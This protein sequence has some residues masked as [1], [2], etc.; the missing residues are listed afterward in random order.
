MEQSGFTIQNKFSISLNSLGFFL[1]SYLFVY[2][3]HQIVTCV[4]ATFFHIP[5]LFRYNN[6]LFYADSSSWTFTSVKTIFLSGPIV[7]LFVGIFFLII[8]HRFHTYDGLLRLFF[9]WGAI[10]A[11]NLFYGAMIVGTFTGNGIG[12]A[13]NWMFLMDTGKLLVVILALTCSLVT[14]V[15]LTRMILFTANSYFPA[16]PI[17]QKRGYLRAQLLY[18]FLSGSL[19]LY[20][21]KS[22]VN[23]NDL[24]L[25]ATLMLFIIPMFL[26]QTH[27]PT[28]N[29]DNE[30]SHTI[31]INPILM[32]CT[33]A[34]VILYRTTLAHGIYFGL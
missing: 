24:L 14:G 32:V 1:L 8:A 15:M 10:H 26:R 2:F 18:P 33:L 22:P 4:T 3:L 28:L 21:V 6:L 13:L 9:L 20:F 29:F 7:A 12:Y 17:H 11:F 25:P 30:T 31:N 5:S 23:T 16:L 19:L 27:F 34:G